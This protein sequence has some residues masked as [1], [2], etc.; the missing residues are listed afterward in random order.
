MKAN[1]LYPD[2]DFDAGAPPP[3]G[4]DDLVRDLHLGTL[5]EA[6]GDG[7]GYLADVARQVVPAGLADAEAIR[8]RQDVLADCLANPQVVRELYALAVAASQG[9]KRDFLG[10]LR[11]TPDLVLHHAIEVLEMSV[12]M[13]RRLRGLADAEAGRFR[14]A[15]FGTFFAMVAREL[16]D[17]YLGALDEHVR[18]LHFRN[19]MLVSAALGPGGRGTDHVLRRPTHRPGWWQRLTADVPETR[20]YRVP[21]RDEAGARALAELRDRGVDPVATALAQATEHIVAFFGTLRLEL[22]FYLGCLNVHDRL[23]RLGMPLCRPRPLAAAAGADTAAAGNGGDTGDGGDT[24]DTGDGD[25]AA[26]GDGGLA[27]SGLY[28]VCLALRAPQ[29]RVVGNDVAAAD[30]DLIVIT[31]ANQ[32]GKSTLLRAVGQAYVMLRC[33]MSVAAAELAAAPRTGVFTHFKREE[34]TDMEHGKLDEELARMAG[35][36]QH[37]RPGGL[38]L[39]NESFAATNEREG[40]ELSRQI[41][42]ALRERRVGVVTVTHLYR[43]ACALRRTATGSVF[44]RAERRADGRRTFRVVPG[45][46]LP[47]SYGADLYRSIFGGDE[48]DRQPAPAVLGGDHLGH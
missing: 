11:T 31:G 28:D 48:P 16:D 9:R 6:M 22:A 8:H 44:L 19:G 36:A 2:R 42:Q 26:T 13:L 33:G 43:L 39:F 21:E 20:T 32:G 35:I 34:D 47:T 12:G 18:L 30:T 17:D 5:F 40:S 1:L 7:D 37:L 24:A 29:Q 25:L 27:A 38:V 15:G 46:P 41:I 23:D 4:T 3:F 14:S 10:Y 45:E